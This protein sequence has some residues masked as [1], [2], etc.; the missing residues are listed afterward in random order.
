MEEKDYKALYEKELDWR[1]EHI[2]LV[3]NRLDILLDGDQCDDCG[4]SGVKVYAT[5]GTY[6]S[7]AGGCMPTDDV[8]DKCWG[9]GRKSKPWPS[10]RLLS[11]SPK[12]N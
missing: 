10:H 12:P 11:S 4:G 2:S 5:T 3:A 8:C 7:G 1:Y 9:S 6:R